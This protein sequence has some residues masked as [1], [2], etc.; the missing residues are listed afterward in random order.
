MLAAPVVQ[1]PSPRILFLIDNLRPGGAQKVLLSIVKALQQRTPVEPIVWRLGGTSEIE[2]QFRDLNV[3]VLGGS[4]S[5]LNTLAQPIALFRMLRK[6]RVALVQTFLFHSDITGRIIGRLARLGR[7]V[8]V[9]VSSVRATNVRNR[10]WQFLLQ[11]ATAPLSDMFT[12]VSRR[13]LEFAV[14]RE[15]VAAERACVIPNGIDLVPWENSPSREKARA[16]LGLPDGDV[17]IGSVGRLHAQKGHADLLVA[18][19]RVVREYNGSVTFVI[20]GYGPLRDVLEARAKKLG[21]ESR[22][23]FLGYRSDVP[24]IL[25][26]L[27]VFVL[28]SLWEGM[29]N[30][31]L[32]AMAAGKPVVATAVDGNVEQ[33]V[34]GCTGFLVPPGDADALAEALLAVVRDSAM[35]KEMGRRG[36]ERVAGE[37]PIERMTGLHIKLYCDLLH[38]HAGLSRDEWNCH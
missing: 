19:Q 17:V 15:G 33:V 30:A 4:D 9:V 38:E 26:A 16:A 8:P 14:Q 31:I 20:A 32:E 24:L 21:L 6:E 18:A 7:R 1:E 2:R 13:T 36:R 23:R 27:D 34:D 3:R 25:S 11:R 28:P 37:F 5:I 29:S 12:A 22:I 35:M 10:W